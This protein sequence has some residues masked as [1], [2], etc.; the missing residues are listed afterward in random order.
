MFKQKVVQF[1]TEPRGCLTE[2]EDLE[3]GYQ[4]CL[5]CERAVLV[6][7]FLLRAPA[8]WDKSDPRRIW[9]ARAPA[10]VLD[11]AP[12]PFRRSTRNNSDDS[13][14]TVGLHFRVSS[15]GARSYFVFRKDGG[16]VWSHRPCY[17]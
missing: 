12:V 1:A 10:Y 13:L 5:F 14:A 11:Y 8:G 17:W 3:L 9:R 15:L 6:G 16:A 7:M 2:L 4:K